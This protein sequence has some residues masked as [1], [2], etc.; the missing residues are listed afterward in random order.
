MKAI[1]RKLFLGALMVSAGIS[2]ISCNDD[3]AVDPY[4]INYAYIY[5]PGYSNHTISYFED[6]T[7]K[8]AI[9]EEENI[10]PARCTRL[11]PSDLKIT[12]SVDKSLVDAYNE[13]H[14]S[15]YVFLKNA[16]LVNPTLTI[17]K[18]ELISADTL[19][20]RYTDMSEFKD[21]TANY[22]LPITITE[23]KGGG[24]SV[25][26]SRTFYLTYESSLIL[27]E[28]ASSPTGTKIDDRSN[29]SV[30]MNGKETDSEGTSNNAVIDG[31]N[32]TYIYSEYAETE[33]LFDLKATKKI[34][35]ITFT[36]YAWYYAPLKLSVAVSADGTNYDELGSVGLS[37]TGSD[38]INLYRMKNVQFVKM[39]FTGFRYYDAIAIKEINMYT[40]E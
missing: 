40:P 12:F 17:K 23:V 38:I 31:N 28:G 22:I 27:M 35:S 37:D 1:F 16:E 20:V 36:F 6:G 29:W 19:N 13:K 7:F 10:I 5:A 21:G 8:K 26:E 14:G 33:L 30:L 32:N 39:K 25:S 11:A 2:V 9:D 24:V 15:H 3:D 34:S 18:G 4:D